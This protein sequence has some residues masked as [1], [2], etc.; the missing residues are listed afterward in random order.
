M[1]KGV[2]LKYTPATKSLGGAQIPSKYLCLLLEEESEYKKH[3]VYEEGET[4]ESLLAKD[5]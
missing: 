1:K 3:I 2:I 5:E 4:Y